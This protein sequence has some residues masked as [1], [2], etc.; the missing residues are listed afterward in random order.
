M[1]EYE[2]YLP[3]GDREYPNDLTER[4]RRE[5]IEFFGGLTDTR[6]PNK[7]LWRVGSVTIKDEILVWRVLS[8]RGEEGR[9][10]LKA[11]RERLERDMHQDEILIVARSVETI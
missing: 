4:Y 5:L 7:G 1:Q 10:F 6:H 3:I 11:L 2:I 9:A 8:D